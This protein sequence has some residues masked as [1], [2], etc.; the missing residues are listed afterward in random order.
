MNDDVVE[1][2]TADASVVGSSIRR[3]ASTPDSRVV[4]AAAAAAA[5]CKVTLATSTAAGAVGAAA[6]AR[7]IG[8]AAVITPNGT[9]RRGVDGSFAQ[10]KAASAASAGRGGAFK[11][12]GP[13]RLSMD[14]PTAA[15][16]RRSG[17]Q[18]VKAA[19]SG[20]IVRR[21]TTG[22][23]AAYATESCV[24]DDQAQRLLQGGQLPS[25]S[26]AANAGDEQWQQLER[27]WQRNWL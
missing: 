16:C 5:S 24:G 13:S 8:V 6:A 9:N 4:A 18:S 25:C 23:L 27:V 1:A 3:T 26:S 15:T 22:D 12:R 14:V 19:V 2:P 11:G 20:A 17:L 10:P 7:S 21:S